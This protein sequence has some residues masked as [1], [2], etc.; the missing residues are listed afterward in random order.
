LN[1]KKI[2]IV[3]INPGSTSTKI[4]VYD[5][6][7]L[8]KQTNITH[9]GEDLAPF[10]MV[11][12]EYEY[13]FKT[14]LRTLEEMGIPLDSI[15]AVS[16]RGGGLKPIPSGTFRVTA[17]MVEDTRNARIQ[18]ASLLGPMIS[19]ALAQQLNIPAFTV[20]PVNVDELDDVARVTGLGGTT[21]VGGFHPLNHKAV[22]RKAAQE[23]GKTYFDVNFI[24]A[25]VG[26]GISVGAHKKGRAVEVEGTLFSPE[27][28]SPK[29]FDMFEL[30]TGGKYT[31]EEVRK[32]MM[33]TGGIYSYFGTKDIRDIEKMIDE[34][35]KEAELVFH[36]LAYN[37]AKAIGACYSVL[38][39][40]VD[41]LVVTGG[42]AHSK[43]FVAYI[44]DYCRYI[45]KV[46]VFPGENELESLALG[47]LRVM[48]GEEKARVYPSG[49]FED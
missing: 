21:R 42:V 40:E 11:R 46:L 16:G 47:A 32:L 45:N 24:V 20:D 13:R 5:N 1:K 38:R 2:R 10:K 3:S 29:A 39:G 30:C 34:G 22:A 25:H 12:D 6:E 28:V 8:V 31:K 18:H 26:G 43:R 19:Y 14:V 33:G 4:A 37:V 27:R 15:D 35:N 36:A 23:L 17:A 9:T 44:K 49:A 7:E 41:A 48:R